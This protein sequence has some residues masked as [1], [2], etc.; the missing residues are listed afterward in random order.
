MRNLVIQLTANCTDHVLEGCDADWER[1]KTLLQIC[2][3]RGT[4][5]LNE[6]LSADAEAKRTA[7]ESAGWVP[8]SLK[9]QYGRRVQ[10]NM[11]MA[12]LLV[13]DIDNGLPLER[14]HEV[15]AQYEYAVHSSY[16]HTPEKPKWR[17]VLPLAEAIPAIYLP[18]LFDRI[19]ELFGGKLDV[20][21]GHDCARMYFL[22]GCPPDAEHLFVFEHHPGEWLNAASMLVDGPKTA[23]PVGA[24]AIEPVATSDTGI[25]F[26]AGYPDGQR[27]Q[28][29]VRRAGYCL[30]MGMPLDEAKTRCLQWNKLNTPPLEETKVIST[31]ESIA[32]THERSEIEM[33]EHYA[34]VIEDMNRQYAWIERHGLVYRFKFRD[35]ISTD[36]LRQ[37][38]ANTHIRA[39]HKGKTKDLTHAE[40][41]LSSPDR[42]KFDDLV[43]IPGKPQIHDGSI[44]LW[45][46][47]GVA[48]ADGDVTPWNQLLD[49]LFN[50]DVEMRRWFE[51][52]AAYPIQ[53]PGEKMNTAVVFWSSQQGVGKTL[54]GETIGLIYGEHF[55]T[56]SAT[57]L[58]GSFNGWARDCQF[59]LGEE[60]SSA[61][62]RA[63][64]N[65]LKHLITGSTVFVN[66]KYLPA[67]V[68]TN[69]VNFIFTS[70]HPD[71]FHLE[72]H[73]RRFFVWSITAPK[74]RDEF[75]KSFV[76]WRDSGGAAALMHYFLQLDL[77]EFNPKASA[78]LTESKREMIEISRSEVERWI[79][80]TLADDDAITGVF[81]REVATMDEV[82]L[83]YHRE[84]PHSRCNTTA[85]SRALRRKH[86]YSSCRA[87]THHGR[88]SLISLTNHDEWDG[89][90]SRAW[91]EEY[92]KPIPLSW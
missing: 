36:K 28:E 83:A 6:Y 80:E 91:A 78:P 90:D 86:R 31:V 12:H 62:H 54:I 69:R 27:T 22:P 10:A 59:V 11:D 58:H 32:R 48:P 79:H 16:S 55:K 63:D 2:H 44:N 72:A 52:W 4:L 74:M 76:K 9:D 75:Y 41:W 7:K 82:I 18:A 64:S 47:W 88:K 37:Q 39:I 14:I 66:E 56:I 60:N 33:K 50:G 23:E 46:G 51:C 85:M 40:A 8:C 38:L 35:L 67:M 53:N 30:A 65:K 77:S 70:N 42:R 71:A 34:R 20:S 5:T 19:N 13:L 73:D 84:H 3:P 15:L 25:S 61:D 45:R 43:F 89:R 57:E 29:L 81:G 26:E 17:V 24:T 21:C 49:H 87:M 1:L 68:M 92:K